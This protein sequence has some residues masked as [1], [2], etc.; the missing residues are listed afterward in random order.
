MIPFKL[1]TIITIIFCI[2]TIGL[3]KPTQRFLTSSLKTTTILQPPQHHSRQA[4]KRLALV[5]ANMTGTALQ[6][7]KSK[8]LQSS[9][10][11]HKLT[12]SLQPKVPTGTKW[13]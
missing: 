8:S 1:Q 4:T 13:P 7:S 6:D 5:T 10:R 12:P 11:K 2:L 3:F 9:M